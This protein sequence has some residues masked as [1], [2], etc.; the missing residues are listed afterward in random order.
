MQ[1]LHEFTTDLRTIDATQRLKYNQ[2]GEVVFNF[3]KYT[4]QPVLQ[5]LLK[6]RQYY[7]WI[8]T[9]DFSS[10]VKQYVKKLMKDYETGKK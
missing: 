4:G 1:A 9:K 6:D 10:Q 3:G 5:T 8:L 7:N 2:K